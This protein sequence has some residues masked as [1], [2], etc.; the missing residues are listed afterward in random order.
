MPYSIL[1]LIFLSFNTLAQS[2][3]GAKVFSLENSD[4]VLY[5]IKIQQ[6]GI[7]RYMSWFNPKNILV[8]KSFLKTKD[9]MLIQYGY[10][11]SSK[12]LQEV[13]KVTIEK[14]SIMFNKSF[15]N[16]VTKSKISKTSNFIVG[17]Q[18]VDFIKLNWDKL[19]QGEELFFELGVLDLKKAVSFKVYKKGNKVIMKVSNIFYR[20]FV[21]PIIFEFSEDGSQVLTMLGRLLPVTFKNGKI[22]G[23]DGLVRFEYKKTQ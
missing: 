3:I 16:E 9:N 4:E 13:S 1:I 2:P 19:S 6:E 11:R 18:I 15:N 21:D 23:G 7:T 5:T 12:N 20:I 8:A 10:T 14:N 22:Q 17:S